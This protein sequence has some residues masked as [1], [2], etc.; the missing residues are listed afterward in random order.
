VGGVCILGETVGGGWGKR[1]WQWLATAGLLLVAVEARN[2]FSVC[3]FLPTR[4]RQRLHRVGRDG[5]RPIIL[6]DTDGRFG[7]AGLRC[8]GGRASWPV[9]CAGGAAFP[10]ERWDALHAS[11]W[12][13]RGDHHGGLSQVRVCCGCGAGAGAGAVK[14]QNFTRN[15]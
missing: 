11:R 8:D 13:S 2:H 5:N 9:I 4:A 6:C 14:A 3:F 7:M 15:I 1:Q 10:R 12:M